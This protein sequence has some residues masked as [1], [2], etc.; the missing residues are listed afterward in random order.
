MCHAGSASAQLIAQLV[1]GRVE[2]LE[3]ASVVAVTM[4]PLAQDETPD[5]LR[6]GVAG[7]V[8]HC[9]AGA[10]L[11][12]PHCGAHFHGNGDRDH[13]NFEIDHHVAHHREVLALSEVVA[14]AR[15]AL[16]K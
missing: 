13:P 12:L 15:P 5:A 3:L 10:D 11:G 16:T 6:F 8:D 1:L 7:E 2:G 14:V 9:A 4:A